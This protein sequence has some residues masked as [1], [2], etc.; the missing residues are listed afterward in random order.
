MTENGGTKSKQFWNLVRSIKRNNTEEMYAI[1]TEDGQRF[2]I[3]HDIKEQTETY[4]QKLYTPRVLPAY[5]QS[6]TN[7]TEKQITIF[8]ENKQHEK[9]YYNRKI[10]I[11]EV[12]KATQILKNNKSTRAKLIKNEFLKYGGNK[13]LKNNWLLFSMKS[14]IMNKYHNHG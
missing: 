2:S 14:S 4:Y 3:E 6:W 12:K 1:T 11:Q 13:I 5:N 7:F 9:E 8:G 10:T